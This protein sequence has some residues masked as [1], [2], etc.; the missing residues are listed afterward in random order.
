MRELPLPLFLTTL[1][2][3][4]PP[5]AEQN[6]SI[7]DVAETGLDLIYAPAAALSGPRSL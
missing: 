3:R 1:I 5:I 4:R 6:I 2:A 7:T